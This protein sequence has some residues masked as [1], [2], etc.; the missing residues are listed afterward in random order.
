MQQVESLAVGETMVMVAPTERAAISP[1]TTFML[2]PGGAESNVALHLARLGHDS[3]WAGHLGDDPFGHMILDHLAAADVRVDR[4]RV[5]AGARTGVYFKDVREGGTE[6]L[7]YRAGSAA[8]LMGPAVADELADLRA[9]VLHLTGITP[10]LSA[11]CLRL[12]RRLLLDRAVAADVVSF[13]VNFRPGLWS[14]AEA[15]PV[16][17]ELAEAADVVFVGLDEARALWDAR[18]PEDVRRALPSPAAVVVKNHGE[19]A[20]SFHADGVAHVP[21]PAIEIVEPVGAGDAFA[22]GWLSGLLRGLPHAE[23]LSLGHEVAGHVLTTTFDDVEFPE[24]LRSSA[25]PVRG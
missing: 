8:S 10:A 22:A 2:R 5:V 21:A 6:V 12:A 23:R 24:A 16:L 14:A 4:A 19:G 1:A 20:T 15:G 9:E 7:Y 25:R 18:S 11:S 17:R 13:D 3:A